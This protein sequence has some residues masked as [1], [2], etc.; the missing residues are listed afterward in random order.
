MKKLESLFF[1]LLVF[2]MPVQARLILHRWTQPF[3]QWTSA[4]LYGTDILLA[5]IF[6]LWL[7]RVIGNKRPA[8]DGQVHLPIWGR[9]DLWLVLFFLI[10]LLSIFQSRLVWLS[11][12]QLIK[13]AEFIGVYFYF[14][15]GVDKIFDFQK[16]LLVIIV[17]GLFQSVIAIAQ[18][19]K[20]ASLGLRLLGES[21]LSVNGTGVAV[22][23][24]DG[25]KYLRAYGTTPHPNVLAAWLF[26]A[27]FAFYFYYLWRYFFRSRDSNSSVTLT[28]VKEGGM[29]FVY[30]VMLF[31][32]FFTFSRVIIGL[33]VLGVIAIIL[34]D[35]F[36]KDFR[37]TVFKI[38]SRIITLTGLSLITAI[39][40]SF[41]FW[42]QVKSRIH[43]SAEEEAISQRIFYNKIAGSVAI[44]H[45][46]LGVGIG[47]F[48][49]NL[50]AK[51]R[52][53]PAI[54]YQPVH[55]IYLLI[56]SETGFLGLALF[57]VFLFFVFY[58][59]ICRTNFR[60]LYHLSFFILAAS[61]L[62]LG[63]FDHL[64]WTLQQGS[65]IFWMALALVSSDFSPFGHKA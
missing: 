26:V 25:F 5:A 8:P 6:I 30:V 1:Y 17:S 45:P 59:F 60:Q 12:Y 21:Q 37:S 18:Y 50:M 34:I 54:I 39:L 65:L 7:I 64:L 56:V 3:N 57:L 22:F 58:N 31:A 41:L 10:S 63:L 27:I 48:V 13:L 52:H 15:G 36:K 29:L 33:W 43:I 2:M 28:L 62:L 19:I 40:F 32:L 23:I 42:P 44:S 49:P 61:F 35:F 46:L 24:A 47:Q 16:I 51:S 53:L 38:R 4:Y 55:N 11:V 20:Q 14:K 9:P